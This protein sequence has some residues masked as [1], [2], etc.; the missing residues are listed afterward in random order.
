MAK[1]NV[2][3]DSGL[4]DL[5]I[6]TAKNTVVITNQDTRDAVFNVFNAAVLNGK[7][8]GEIIVWNYMQAA[9]TTGTIA[10]PTTDNNGTAINWTVG[11]LINPKTGAT[12]QTIISPPWQLTM[13]S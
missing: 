8:A 3:L 5:T 6:D 9:G 7:P 12:T 10:I 1:I 13:V 11:N 2:S 4:V